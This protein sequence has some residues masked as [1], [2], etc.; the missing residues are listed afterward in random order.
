MTEWID[1]R[2]HGKSI[3]RNTKIKHTGRYWDDGDDDND[4]K[5]TI[6]TFLVKS[7]NR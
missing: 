5:R 1:K 3:V 2:P 7:G 4:D 6:S